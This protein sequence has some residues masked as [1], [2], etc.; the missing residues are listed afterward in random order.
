MIRGHYIAVRTLAQWLIIYPN[1]RSASEGATG[2]EDQELQ[3][4][5]AHL[6]D[7]G[8][9]ESPTLANYQATLD[10]QADLLR[11]QLKDMKDDPMLRRIFS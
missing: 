6:R 9:K 8:L 10:S 7:E 3:E 11:M 1:P 4:I 2:G 5:R